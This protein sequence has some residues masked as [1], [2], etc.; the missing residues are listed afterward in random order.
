M[1]TASNA[2]PPTA[3]PSRFRRVGIILPVLAAITIAFAGL[4]GPAQAAG[5]SS[6]GTGRA[7]VT[8]SANAFGL[9]FADAPVLVAAGVVPAAPGTG[10]PSGT[11][12]LLSDADGTVL[13]VGD[14]DTEEP[15]L[16]LALMDSPVLALGTTFFKARYSGDSTF[17]P[18]TIRFSITAISGP[19]T[20]TA[21]TVTPAG[22]SVFGAPVTVTARA[23]ALPSGPLTGTPLGSLVLIVDGV[24]VQAQAPG[25]GW[26]SVFTINNLPA[27]Q[28][29]FTAEFRHAEGDY[30]GSTSGPVTHTVTPALA[31]VKGEFHSSHHGD[32]RPGTAVTVQAVIMPAVAGGA[33]PTGWVQFYDWNTKVGAPVKLVNGKAG[34]THTSL[35][36][37][38][39][40]LQAK[41]LGSSTYL[42]AF[43][44]AR[45]VTVVG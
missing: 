22:T 27:G 39:H 36:Y 38:K 14:V 34:Y 21:I 2:A 31:A 7:E 6:Y 26:Q 42:P 17:A 29:V 44:P 10:V 33:T 28:H 9:P 45:T 3:A 13:G 23:T 12:S 32:I 11:V 41:Y 40:V 37:G 18:K 15:F 19:G 30:F 16:G 35:R 4:A 24:E 5:T 20:R 8:L 1:D 25:P 43:T